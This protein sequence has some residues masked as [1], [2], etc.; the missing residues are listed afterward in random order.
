MADAIWQDAAAVSAH[1]PF[2]PRRDVPT[3][4]EPI[5]RE[6]TE[7]LGGEFAVVDV[8]QREM[9]FGGVEHPASQ[10]SLLGDLAAACAL[11]RRA[12]LLL[13]EEPIAFLALPL[14]AIGEPNL[15]A[16]GAFVTR[17]QA[18]GDSLSAAAVACETS[19]TRLREFV[20]R[21][22]TAVPAEALLR[23]GDMLT[24]LWMAERR[25]SNLTKEMETLSEKLANGYEEL[26]LLYA[27]SHKLRLA[28]SESALSRLALEWAFEIAPVEGLA[29]QLL[30]APIGRDGTAA[31]PAKP[32]SAEA[33]ITVGKCPC[34]AATFSRLVA[35]EAIDPHAPPLVRNHM[36]EEGR[37]WAEAG[38]RSVIV[39]PV[40]ENDNLFGW[41][42]A[43]NNRVGGEL[44]TVEARMLG[45]VAAILGVH[46]GNHALYRRQAEFLASVVRALTSA[47][48]AKDPYTRGHS[49]RVARVAVRLAREL[50]V[51]DETAGMLYMAG[52]LH[53][54]GKIGIDDQVLRKPGR[55][56]EGEFEHIKLHPQLGHKILLGIQQLA[57]VLPVVL[58]H[59]EQWDGR[60]YPGGL[61]QENIPFLARICAVADAYDAMSSDRPYRKGMDPALV[62]DIFRKGA[63]KQWDP[64]VV[65]AFL[66][67]RD[68][69]RLISRREHDESETNCSG[70]WT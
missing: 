6:L 59:H 37:P 23:M 55:L 65:D 10:W 2:L 68:E 32:N 4:A 14:G 49:D 57:P 53:D 35:A 26:S 66:R 27:L 58:H 9:I 17:S 39:V 45:S 47:I 42:A 64:Q 46:C 11:H 50:G 15:V 24:S 13:D 12:E 43:F 69:I 61:A 19:E 48:D 16:V 62:D 34:D 52:L 60:G 63:G 54:I 44:G 18:A 36:V 38:I 21:Q 7:R 28:T 29:V 70:Q 56:T 1:V 22:E 3:S 31:N 20:E 51:D 25:S 8:A 41:L 33:W 30:P 5:A 67:I 40:Y